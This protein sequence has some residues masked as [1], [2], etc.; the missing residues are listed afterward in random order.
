MRAFKIWILL[1]LASLVLAGCGVR[2]AYNNLDWLL[3]RW[4]NGQISLNADQELSV[5]TAL[6]DKLLWHCRSELPL[7]AEFLRGVE[8]D[9]AA[10][11]LDAER[12]MAHGEQLAEFGRR[13]LERARPDIIELFASLDDEQVAALREGFDERNEEL[14]EQAESLSESERQRQQV[15]GMERGMRRFAGRITADQRARLEQWAAS[16][17]PTAEATLA[18][19]LDWQSRFF[20]TLALRADRGNFDPQ[21]AALLEPGADWSDEYRALMEYNRQQTVEA[22]ADVHA[23]APERQLRRLQNRLSGWADD[24]DRLSC[25]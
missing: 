12:F 3:M 24:F 14:R 2:S 16:L 17:E 8:S 9:V 23:L 21:M 6:D 1:L 15:E 13:L 18:Q 22:L 10:N 5:R 25:G 7:Y 11:R 20:E 19:R 4:I